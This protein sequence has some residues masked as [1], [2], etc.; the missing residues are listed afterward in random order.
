VTEGSTVRLTAQAREAIVAHAKREQ[1]N[2]CCGLLAGSHGVVDECVPA[3]NLSAS[4]TRYL[5]DPQDHIALNRRLRGTPRRVI[6]AYHSH[7]SSPA[8]PSPTDIAEAQYPEFVWVIVSLAV[9]HV[10]EIRAY[11]IVGGR[12]EEIEVSS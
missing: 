10:P 5:I 7:P 2:E 8:V 12:F 9:P 1:P 4:P 6:G 3:R 11:R